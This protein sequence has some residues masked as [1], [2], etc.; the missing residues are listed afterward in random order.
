MYRKEKTLILVV[1]SSY[2][3]S[4]AAQIRCIF[5]LWTRA[6]DLGRYI[7]QLEVC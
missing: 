4:F 3:T 1:L 6:H 7:Y 5:W 2:L